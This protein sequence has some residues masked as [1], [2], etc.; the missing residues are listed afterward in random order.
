MIW[1]VFDLFHAL[2]ALLLYP[3]RWTRWG[4]ERVAF[5][6]DSDNAIGE[7]DWSFEVSSEGEFEQVKLWLGELLE[8][9]KKIELVY[10]SPSVMKTVKNLRSKYP[11]HLRLIPLPLLTHTPWC[12]VQELTAPRLVLC[13]YD[14]F[15]S[16]MARASVSTVRAGVVWGSFTYRRARLENALWRW[17]YRLIYGQFDWVVPA[18][19]TDARLFE[20]LGQSRVLPYSEMR[21]PQ[22]MQRLSLREETLQ[23]KFPHWDDFKT[24]LNRYRVDQRWI[25]GSAWPVDLVLLSNEELRADIRK[26]ETCFMV[27]PHQLA[28]PWREL[29]EKFEVPVHVIDET[30]QGGTLGPGVWLILLKG[31]LCELYPEAGH[32]YVG[33][34]F[35][36]SVHSVLEPFVAGSLVVTGPKIH[37]STEVEVVKEVSNNGLSVMKSL[38]E[39]SRVYQRQKLAEVHVANREQWLSEQDR[40]CRENLI[41][42][43]KC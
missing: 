35:G 4:R 40:C 37:R 39:L 3:V 19:V 29:L 27:V 33:G 31:V 12:L 26:G 10:S 9:G 17:W 38:N 14:F 6:R 15:P 5:E 18:T 11:T 25:M 34:G 8:N 20:R 16:L 41:E 32:V 28:G 23:K 22:I 1:R 30:W 42:V 2:L 7:C 21:V 13:R 36:K 24:A 43:E